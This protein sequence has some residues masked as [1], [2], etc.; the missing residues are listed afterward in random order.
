MQ[1]KEVPQY[2]G[3]FA[4]ETGLIKGPRGWIA[5]FPNKTGYLRFNV[6]LGAG[7]LTQTSVHIAVC[8][9]FHGPRPDGRFAAHR[10]G[11]KLNNR[12][13]NL[14]WATSEENERDKREHGRSLLGERHHQAKLTESDVQEI[15]R[16]LST[17]ERG[18]RLA[19]EYGVTETTIS[20]IKNRKSWGHI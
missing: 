4:T 18:R 7:K 6:S 1:L 8:S 14:Y 9:A 5:P 13:D 19:K 20:Y 12:A 10:D 11:D 2:P 17:G 16:R 15:R 3:Y